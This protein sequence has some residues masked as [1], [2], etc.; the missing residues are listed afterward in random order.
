MNR[1]LKAVLNRVNEENQR[2]TE[3]AQKRLKVYESELQNP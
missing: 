3:S 1:F 2:Q